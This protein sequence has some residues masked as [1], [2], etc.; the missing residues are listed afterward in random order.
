IAA[1]EAA[2]AAPPAAPP[3]TSA[4][5]RGM[6]FRRVVAEGVFLH[7]KEIF[8]ATPSPRGAGF[9]VLTPLREADGRIVFVNRGFVPSQLKDPNTRRAGEIEGTVRVA[10]LLRLPPD[11]KPGRFLPDNRAD[12][13]YWF[14]VDLPAIA[15][16]NG[17]DNVAPFYIEADATPNPGGWPLGKP[18]ATEL[19]NNHLQ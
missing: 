2:L 17:L 16:A 18:A 5:A 13:N 10:G 14:W 3:R 9:D 6:A 7:D 15:G 4:E 8:V 1:R 12:I 11:E 19:P